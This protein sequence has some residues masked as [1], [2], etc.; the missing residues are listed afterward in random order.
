MLAECHLQTGDYDAAFEKLQT[1]TRLDSDD[2]RSWA[3][4]ARC[5][6]ARENLE[7][8]HFAARRAVSLAPW[9]DGPQTVLGI[10]L[11]RQGD[12]DEAE[13]TLQAAVHANPENIAA[14]CLLGRVLES[15]AG[16]Q[17]A[18]QSYRQALQIDPQDA[19]AR[20][21]Y[22]KLAVGPEGEVP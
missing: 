9:A 22:D 20:Q 21:L 3:L 18:L 12:W 6:L 1:L 2:A 5:Q 11:Y 4:L 10:V 13:R 7:Q 15:S 16:P 14:L 17:L 8:A 19:L